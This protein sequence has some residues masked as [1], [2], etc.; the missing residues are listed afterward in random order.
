MQHNKRYALFRCGNKVR[1]KQRDKQKRIKQL[2]FTLFIL[3]EKEKKEIKV[4][5]FS[6]LILSSKK[7]KGTKCYVYIKTF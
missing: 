4:K 2:V 5:K 7:R 1:R 3:R 6:L